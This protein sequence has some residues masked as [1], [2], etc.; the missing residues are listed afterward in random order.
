VETI[1]T[2]FGDKTT[3]LDLKTKTLYLSTAEYE[4]AEAGS[5]C[6]CVKPGTFGVLLVSR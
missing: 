2:Q 4:A 6:R 1:P 3:A 5:N